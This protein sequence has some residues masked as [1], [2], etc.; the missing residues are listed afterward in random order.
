MAGKRVGPLVTVKRSCNGCVH[1]RSDYYAC[2]GDSGFHVS[3]A[4]PDAPEPRRIGNSSWDTP[5]W[6][7]ELPQPDPPRDEAHGI[8]RAVSVDFSPAIPRTSA[9]SR[10]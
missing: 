7:P 4:H 6:C 5:A 10:K 8:E 2:Q 1:E 9:P 3:C